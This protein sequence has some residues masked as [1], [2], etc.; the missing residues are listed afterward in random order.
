MA[1]S[2]SERWWRR[3]N[4]RREPGR[5]RRLRSAGG[6]ALSSVMPTNA[7][8]PKYELDDGT[9]DVAHL[10]LR[11]GLPVWHLRQH[12]AHRPHHGI[13]LRPTQDVAAALERLRTLGDVADR[14]VGHAEDRSTPPAPCRCRTSRRAPRARAGRSRRSR[15]ARAGERGCGSAAARRSRRRCAVRGWTLKSTGRANSRETPTTASTRSARRSGIVHVLC[16]VHGQQEVA[17]RAAR[18]SAPA[19]RWRRSPARNA[20]RTSPMG[21]PVTKIRS[22]SMPSRTRFSLLRT[23]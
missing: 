14:D 23:V 19:H 17:A 21:L 16:A 7:E 4:A 6:G 1:T 5:G 20:S 2:S 3:N 15:A 18:R 10:V 12:Q 22:R 11:R 13:G 8:A 9:S